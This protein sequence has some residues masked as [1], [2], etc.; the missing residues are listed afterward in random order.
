ME[1]YVKLDVIKRAE[2]RAARRR[3]REKYCDDLKPQIGND[4]G[5]EMKLLLRLYDERILEW[6]ANLFDP[7]IGGFYYSNSGRDTEGYL[8]DIESTVQALNSL[9]TAG[10]LKGGARTLPEWVQKKV[11]AFAQSLQDPEDGYFYHPQWGKK[12]AVSRRGRDLSWATQIIRSLGGTPKYPTPVDRAVKKEESTLPDYLKSTEAFKEYLGGMDLATNSYFIGNLLNS[13]Q[14]QIKAA[15]EEFVE[16]LFTWL[17]EHQRPD[18]G[19]WQEAVNYHGAN[20]LMKIS[21]IYSYFARPMKYATEAMEYAVNVA[22]CDRYIHFCCQFY[23]PLVTVSNLLHS[24]EVAGAKEEREKAYAKLLELAPG[25]IRRTKEKIMTCRRE[26]GT[27]SYTPHGT[28]YT[29]QGAPVALYEELEGDVNATA[30]S[31]TGTVRALCRA[32]CI[33]MPPFFTEEDREA[34]LELLCRVEQKPKINP[35]PKDMFF[36]NR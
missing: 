35:K 24:L 34:F 36:G 1:N 11:L 8:P 30:M 7:E 5:E 19:A 9:E 16:M 28:S 25:L 20:G 4:A 26:D 33:P 10:I 15:G 21:L 32:L 3:A 18:N 29:S 14:M 23:N 12:V 31:S 22:M 2:L 27:F 17:E 13:Q 6:Y